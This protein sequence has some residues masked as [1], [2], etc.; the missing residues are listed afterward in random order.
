MDHKD[1]SERELLL[2]AIQ[3]LDN[4]IAANDKDH[5]VFDKRLDAHA[6]SLKMLWS[7]G[8]VTGIVAAWLGIKGHQ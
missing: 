4:S 7:G 5:A 3:K 1:L 8:G 6:S 2:L